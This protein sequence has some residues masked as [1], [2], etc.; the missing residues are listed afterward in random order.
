MF[1][2]QQEDTIVVGRISDFLF[3]LD[4]EILAEREGL[5]NTPK[6]EPGESPHTVRNGDQVGFLF[7]GRGDMNTSLPLILV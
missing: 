1:P 7:R 6:P 4:D 3:T 5:V 2:S